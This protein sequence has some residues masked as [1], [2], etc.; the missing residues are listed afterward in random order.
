MQLLRFENLVDLSLPVLNLLVPLP[1]DLAVLFDI[2]RVL[3][4]PDLGR[5]ALELVASELLAPSDEALVLS[6]VPVSETFLEELLL[7]GG[8]ILG[9]RFG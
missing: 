2:G 6:L 4:G 3:V 9:E 7:L 5:N 1:K 8:L